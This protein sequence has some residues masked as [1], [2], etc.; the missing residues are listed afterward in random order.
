MGLD[1]LFDEV[2]AETGAVDLILLGAAAADEGVEDVGLFVFGDTWTAVGHADFDEVAG[3]AGN[4][5]GGDADPIAV[6]GAVFD[7]VIEKILD[8]VFERHLVGHDEREGRFQILLDGDFAS[9]G[10]ETPGVEG[11]FDDAFDGNGGLFSDGVAG[12]GTGETEDLFDE[13]GKFFALILNERA[14][15][16]DLS[17]IGGHATAKVVGGGADDGEW[18]AKFVG[19]TGDEIHLQFGQ[20]LLLPGEADKQ[21]GG[22]E[23]EAEDGG[24]DAE[25]APT[26]AIDDGV[27][28]PFGVAD[29]ELPA[30]AI[31][32][33]RR[34]ALSEERATAFRTVAFCFF[35]AIALLSAVSG[36]TR[37]GAAAGGF[38]AIHFQETD[39]GFGLEA[40]LV[41][42]LNEGVG[43]IEAVDDA[44]AEGDA[45]PDVA[46][47]EEGEVGGA[48]VVDIDV[49]EEPFLLAARTVFA[50][51]EARDFDHG[52]MGVEVGPAAAFGQASKEGVVKVGPVFRPG[53]REEGFLGFV[54]LEEHDLFPIGNG[55]GDFPNERGV[56]GRFAPTKI[57]LGIGGFAARLFDQGSRGPKRSDR[58]G[59]FFIEVAGEPLERALET[60]LQ[61]GAFPPG[62]FPDPDILQAGEDQA[63]QGEQTNGR[64]G[65]EGA[66]FEIL[67][68]HIY[69]GATYTVPGG[70]AR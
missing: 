50:E 31:E 1:D 53:S 56:A 37:G 65:A 40:G 36:R 55:E 5:V 46:G 54:E 39:G 52:G 67:Q 51:I 9:R 18:S 19:Y 12:A 44:E 32:V 11:L 16:F 3:G 38:K 6:F 21:N 2:Q 33:G 30:A 57:V 49:E 13:G 69:L 14:V 20:V 68:I 22:E 7:G 64:P 70:G 58:G 24:G 29:F 8:G 66:G 45:G 15:T 63:E 35:T 62:E 47:D 34:A 17:R 10:A 26:N 28:R 4:F 59:E 61:A 23:H 41:V 27:E 48:D 25:I 42:G 60:F 43:G